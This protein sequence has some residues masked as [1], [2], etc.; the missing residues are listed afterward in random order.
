MSGLPD[1]EQIR[2]ISKFGIS[3]VTIVF[4]E[5]TDIYRARQLVGERLAARRRGDPAG[6]RHARRS[7]RSPR[8]WARSTS[9]R[10][11]PTKESGVTPME[12][13]TILDWFIAY[14]LRE[15]PGVTE[16]N[17]H[18]GELKTYQVELDPDQLG[19]VPARR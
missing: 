6:V 8:R 5:G 4:E 18:G 17:A 16:I 19:D 10:S 11:R 7:G 9:S 14:Q 2:S 3:V 13:R 1:V 12:L 15:V